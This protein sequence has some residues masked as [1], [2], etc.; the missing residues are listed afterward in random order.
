LPNGLQNQHRTAPPLFALKTDCGEQAFRPE[1]HHLSPP[2]SF[3]VAR[4]S[5]GGFLF[6]DLGNH[7]DRAIKLH[8]WIP[9]AQKFSQLPIFA[10]C[11]AQLIHRSKCNPGIYAKAGRGSS[12]AIYFFSGNYLAKSDLRPF[13]NLSGQAM[14]CTIL[15]MR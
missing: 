7:R 2:I 1:R 8:G 15:V 9:S 10:L 13:S 3:T 4:L 12:A 11:S 6:F 14:G 5:A